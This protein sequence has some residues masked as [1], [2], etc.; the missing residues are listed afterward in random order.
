MTKEESEKYIKSKICNDC[1]VHLGGGKCSDNCKVIEAIKA[2]EKEPCN[3]VIRSIA[4]KLLLILCLV[5]IQTN[6]PTTIQ[7]QTIM[8]KV[9]RPE[10]EIRWDTLTDRIVVV[11][12]SVP[13]HPEKYRTKWD[14]LTDRIVF[15]RDDIPVENIL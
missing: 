12:H 7:A 4:K 11:Q 10:F 8:R 15:I 2:L 9:P 1:S 6:I 5:A 3:D 14:T 13:E